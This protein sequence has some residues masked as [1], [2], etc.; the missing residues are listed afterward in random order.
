[1]EANNNRLPTVAPTLRPPST[2]VDKPRGANRSTK[3]T[4]KLQVL[5]DQL[6]PVP[7]PQPNSHH[8]PE[9]PKVKLPPKSDGVAPGSSSSAYTDEDEDEEEVEEVEEEPDAEVWL[10]YYHALWNNG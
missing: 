4:G 2:P 8:E 3:S 7:G 10:R 5:P 6:E 9:P 1:M